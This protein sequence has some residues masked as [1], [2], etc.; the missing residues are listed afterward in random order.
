MFRFTNRGEYTTLTKCVAKLEAE[1]EDEKKTEIKNKTES[2]M[3][4]HAMKVGLK[5]NKNKK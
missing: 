2:K 3:N 4:G 1:V 5:Q